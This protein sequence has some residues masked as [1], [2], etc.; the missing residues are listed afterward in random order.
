MKREV[1][2]KTSSRKDAPAPKSKGA[3]PRHT[4]VVTLTAL[5]A[6][7]SSPADGTPTA[8]HGIAIKGAGSSPE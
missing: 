6:F 3:Q 8:P 4:P 7:L 1:P 5:I 2:G